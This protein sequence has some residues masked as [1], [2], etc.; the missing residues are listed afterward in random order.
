MTKP[1]SSFQKSELTPV[2]WVCDGQLIDKGDRKFVC[3]NCDRAYRESQKMLTVALKERDAARMDYEGGRASEEA[4]V[5]EANRLLIENTVLRNKLAASEVDNK[6]AL[7][8]LGSLID[9]RERLVKQRDDYADD[10]R[11]ANSYILTL[12]GLLGCHDGESTPE[13]VIEEMKKNLAFYQEEIPLL[14]AR[15]RNAEATINELESRIIDGP[16]EEA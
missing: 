11:R 12:G 3:V 6:Q 14:R 7:H 8:A 9:E 5:R 1:T 15:L 13:L 10:A 2:C 4:S 16:E